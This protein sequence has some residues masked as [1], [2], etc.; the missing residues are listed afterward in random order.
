MRCG[1]PGYVAP[2]VIN[3]KDL[4]SKYHPICDMF[5]VGLIFHVM[6]M[7]VSAVPGKRY[8]E[9]L[10][11]NR[12]CNFNLDSDEYKRLEPEA[13]NLLVKML[14]KSP[15]ERISAA[16]ALK[17]PYFSSMDEPEE[18]E[19]T[20]EEL[21]KSPSKAKFY[22]SCESPLLTSANP[23]RKADRTLKKDS[24]VDFKMGKENVFTGKMDTV[25]ETGSTNNSVGKRFESVVM[26][27]V[28]KFSAKNK[29]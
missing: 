29:H 8:N 9:V 23:A 20:V 14:K 26:P 18:L 22:P 6:L 15:Q 2:E 17:H 19:D 13:H 27:K 24:C 25:A 7:G 12:A 16:E 21:V 5:S 3:I 28:S 1:T 11:Q 4:K 10:A